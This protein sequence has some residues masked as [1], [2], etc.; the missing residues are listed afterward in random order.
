VAAAYPLKGVPVTLGASIIPEALAQTDWRFNDAPG[1]LGGATYGYQRDFSQFI[2]LRAAVGASWK[3]SDKFSIGADIGADYNRNELIA[4]YVF[5]AAPIPGAKTLLALKTDGWGVNGTLG[6]VWRPTDKISVGASWRSMTSFTTHGDA[7]GN[8]GAQ[9]P[10][11]ANPLFHYDAEVDTKLPQI[12]SGGASWQATERLRVIGEVDWVNWAA[13]FNHLDIKLK[14]GSN[15]SLP[16]S[17]EDVDPLYWKDSFVYRAGL[18]YN[19]TKAWTARVGY[20]FGQNPVPSSTLTPMSSAILEH[21]ATC[22][23]EWHNDRW[24]VAAAYQHDFA[25]TSNTGGSS[26]LSSGE[27]LNSSTTVSANWFDLTVGFK[28]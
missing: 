6:A 14:N 22:G 1:A 17:F 24:S 11:L 15:G 21:T 20:S 8:I 3:I 12:V 4:P 28:F 13:A 19:V 16:G 23:L 25:A 26:L 27:F 7:N 9:L 2:A 5:Q 10:A 18:E